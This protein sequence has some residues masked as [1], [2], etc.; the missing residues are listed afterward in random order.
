MRPLPHLIWIFGLVASASIALASGPFEGK[1]TDGRLTVEWSAAADGYAGTLTLGQQSYPSV[2]HG[3]GQSVDGTFTAGAHQ[4]PFTGTLTGDTLLFSTGGKTY[5]LQRHVPVNP[6]AGDNAAPAQAAPPAASVTAGT[7]P[8]GYVVVKSTDTG[9]ALA[10]Q[11]QGATTILSAMQATFADL[12]HYFDGRPTLVH[13]YQ[14]THDANSAGASFT[15]SLHGQPVKGLVSCKLNTDAAS[16]AVLYCGATASP[17]EWKKLTAA[18]P[19]AAPAGG[20][21]AAVASVPL[22][23]YNFPDNTGSI[24]LADGWTTNAPSCNGMFQITGPAGQVIT[25]QLS[26][27]VVTPNSTAVQ[28]NRQLNYNAR[29]MGGPQIPLQLYVAPWDDP[30]N[31]F[32]TLAPQFSQKL[33]EKGAGPFQPENLKEIKQI[34]PIGPNGRAA[35]AS[36]GIATVENGQQIHRLVLARIE[37]D[38]ISNDTFMFGLSACG[39][40]DA[41]FKTDLHIML[42]IMN[43][44]RENPA[45]FARQTNQEIALMNQRFDAEQK[46]HAEVQG[47]YDDYNKTIEHNSLLTS[48]SNTDFD[49]VIRGYRTV[50]DTET[51]DRTSVDLGNVDQI[52]NNL[53]EYDPGRYKEIPLRDELYPLP[54]GQ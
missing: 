30:V 39:A 37:V 21:N 29:Q 13:A 46:A 19:T 10:A 35:F 5:T 16:V 36:Y 43:S 15:A 23:T 33:Q 31:V 44:L 32:N 40:P 24:G 51:G 7:L 53:N 52:V 3:N 54:A 25:E 27:E 22:Q 45:E 1:F 49:E 26:A 50:E 14:D 4:F 2:A 41:T 6:L 9:R 17:G 38:P 42:E 34:P 48:R 47:A 12:S 20:G 8:D 18:T 28:M 11:K